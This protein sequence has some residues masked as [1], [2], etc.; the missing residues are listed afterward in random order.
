[1]TLA[2]ENNRTT[3]DQTG[4]KKQRTS[5]S[6]F[7]DALPPTLLRLP[8]LDPVDVSQDD[9]D[10]QAIDPH[11]ITTD[12][13]N[14]NDH[15]ANDHATPAS[16]SASR[17]TDETNDGKTD[18]TPAGSVH[19]TGR[20][21]D[22]SATETR[23]D[24]QAAVAANVNV[25]TA[26]RSEP[27]PATAETLTSFGAIPNAQAAAPNNYRIDVAPTSHAVTSDPA[28]PPQTAT[29]QV[30]PAQSAATIPIASAPTPVETTHEENRRDDNARQ[31]DSR[32]ST[33]LEAMASRKALLVVLLL[34]AG[35]AVFT[36]RGDENDGIDSLVAESDVAP[37]EPAP[38]SSF[39]SSD[40]SADAIS[41]AMI[42]NDSLSS[43]E[44][45]H[46]ASPPMATT[47][48]TSPLA[49]QMIQQPPSDPNNV[50]PYSGSNGGSN[51]ASLPPAHDPGYTSTVS[52]S[53]SNEPPFPGHID[54]A[55]TASPTP[56]HFDTASIGQPTE[57]AMGVDAVSQTPA[58][59]STNTP[60]FD[61][62]RL[63]ALSASL[64]AAANE[65]IRRM[66]A[67]RAAAVTQPTPSAAQP[68]VS[69]P[70]DSP[71]ITSEPMVAPKPAL[72]QS[73]T[74]QA[75]TDW[76]Q[77]LPP[78]GSASFDQPTPAT[79]VSDTNASTGAR[80]TNLPDEPDFGF[81]LPG[82]TTADGSAG[83]PSR[84]TS[85]GNT[86][87]PTGPEAR[88]AMPAGGYSGFGGLR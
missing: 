61:P 83:P 50:S 82:G 69:Q 54:H 18:T 45:S 88:V 85:T 37:G 25:G 24:M 13:A 5:R 21:H 1:M 68:T 16:G 36:P 74:P 10:L 57:P 3:P 29:A 46:P 38:V 81:A 43:P 20:P 67:A 26:P 55:S 87:S 44:N 78:I 60:D 73:R 49:S 40:A 23:S 11:D 8:D 22:D 84:S 72:Q 58:H 4:A 35:I 7:S 52:V 53:Q 65:E 9:V 48:L 79:P 77:Y 27:S 34:V 19:A 30:Q 14:A 12:A 15:A 32:E 80:T 76:K 63:D 51:N 41:D 42:T 47:H 39:A 17:A 2:S 31:D 59:R 71:A 75:I 33:L 64:A 62:D 86:T 28:T 56:P 66:D 70:G 6:Q